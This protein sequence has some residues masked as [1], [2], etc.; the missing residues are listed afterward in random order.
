VGL[1]EG[2]SDQ[3]GKRTASSPKLPKEGAFTSLNLGEPRP[4]LA[5]NVHNI[6]DNAEAEFN[7]PGSRKS[8]TFTIGG[9]KKLTGDPAQ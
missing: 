3:R 2:E 4:D 9:E 1:V 8:T 7:I 6:L 5:K